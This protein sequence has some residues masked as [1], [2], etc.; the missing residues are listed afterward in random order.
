MDILFANFQPTAGRFAR[1]LLCCLVAIGL[2]AC[3][4]GGGSNDGSTAPAITAQ[5]VSV[6]VNAGAV[7]S[8]SVAATG[9]DPLTYQWQKNSAA[10]AGATSAS[11]TTP[12]TVAGDTGAQFTVVVSNAAG[13]VTSNPATLT[14]G[15]G[16]VAPVITAQP[17]AASV[18]APAPATFTVVATGTGPLTYQW[19]K[20]GSTIA[21]ATAASYTT[22]ATS[23]A[24]TNTQFAVVVTN[25]GGSTATSAKA[26]L[27]VTT[28][29]QA[30]TITTQPAN[31][32]VNSGQ[33]AS[34]SVVAAGTA[35][36]NYQWSKN[37]TD[38]SGA[39]AASYTTP[40]TG[41][42][43]TGASF[44]VVVTNSV[45]SVTS[46]DAT[47]TV[48]PAPIAP[49]ITAQP[50]GVI[51]IAG[52]AASFTVAAT[53]NPTLTYQ[54][55]RGTTPIVGATSATYTL[56]TTS[57]TDNGAQFSVVVANLAGS[58]PSNAATLTVAPVVTPPTIATQPS[59]TSVT[60]G[61]TA[62]FSV[63]ATGTSPFTY[64][65][66]KNGTP[67]SGATAASYTTPA[68]V[69]GDNNALFSVMVSNS[70]NSVT[71]ADAKLTVGT[72]VVPPAI[73]AQPA[74][75]TV[76]VGNTGTF[77]V[78]AIGTAPLAYQWR[79]NG[80]L[81]V[82]ANS[83]TYT[84][85]VT[86][87]LDDQAAFTVVVS[88]AYTTTATST[89]AVLTIKLP[90]STP[91]QVAAGYGHSVA[92]R[93]SGA[94]YS[95]GPWSTTAQYNAVAGAGLVGQPAGAT[96]RAKNVD[97]TPF[98]SV[99]G[100]AAGYSHSVAV[101]TDGT[102]WAWGDVGTAQYGRCPLGDGVCLTRYYGVQVKDAAG[103]PFTGA[104]Q[105]SAGWYF[106]VARKADGSVWSWGDNEYGMLGDGTTT[107]RLNP[108]QVTDPTTGGY[109]GGVSQVAASLYHVVAL[110]TNGTVFA[111]GR[112]DSGQIGDGGVTASVS[113][114]K[115]VEVSPGVP[116]TGVIAVAAGE[117]HSIAVKSDG[118]VYAWGENSKGAIGDGTTTDRTRATVMRDT[119]G[120]PITSV[121]AVAA[122]TQFSVLLMSD[123][124][125]LTTGQN[126]IGQL[127][128]NSTAASQI[129]PVLVKDAAGTP[130][131]LVTGISSFF[132]HTVVKRSDGTVWAWGLNSSYQLGDTTN[133]NRR[134]PVPAPA[135]TP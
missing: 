128:D 71:S 72:V 76:I 132:K 47:L 6:T 25:P 61:Q 110:K 92:L 32:T 114:P 21:G 129:N 95:W 85:P 62:S 66:R 15:G 45:T 22:P 81:I 29:A 99:A 48:T 98:L 63:V 133:V 41:D 100:I 50:T 24:D 68:T 74:A 131:G 109:L 51:V 9:T 77:S 116:L 10:I 13:T 11:Y 35:P 115:Q 101:K 53:G 58:V 64:Q 7:A 108:V 19:T 57:L 126:D 84:T 91:S 37:G 122:G 59:D 1:W 113:V 107:F 16:I 79:K 104:T 96:V 103:V 127:G 17:V 124:T 28:A 75:A 33:T 56:T 23:T 31:R 34:F 83:A 130:F 70:A 14:V 105:V 36:F 82:G 134:N 73:T 112:A 4:G 3:G 88:N 106:S 117:M 2:A 89:A 111:W 20:N 12:A 54:W 67:I 69:A 40:A 135:N 46:N 97:N 78:S 118:T 87:F 8:F 65:W 49:T 86:S 120:T 52:Q 5:P 80:V 27:T 44:H 43:D 38:I 30:P 123:G 94:V 55:K 26:T 18:V 102:V 90:P 119:A 42:A 125:V 60:V 93:T 121:V 39:T